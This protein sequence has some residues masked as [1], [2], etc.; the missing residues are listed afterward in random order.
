MMLTWAYVYL[1]TKKDWE[2]GWHFI[3]ACGCDVAI[4][5][6]IAAACIGRFI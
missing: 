3:I 1:A 6:Y 4:V 2:N 5:Y